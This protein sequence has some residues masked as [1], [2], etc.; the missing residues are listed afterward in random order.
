MNTDILEKSI[1]EEIDG[2]EAETEK[3]SLRTLL[4]GKR[5]V[6]FISINEKL[7]RLL[8]KRGYGIILVRRHD[9]DKFSWWSIVYNNEGNDHAHILYKLAQSKHGYLK[10]RTPDEAREIGRLLGYSE[11]SIKNFIHNKYGR[12]PPLIDDNPDN[13]NDLHEQIQKTKDLMGKVDVI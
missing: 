3:G 1:N 7:R 12:K 8:E 10:D 2:R 13:Y 4:G 6:A 11:D 5:N 9:I